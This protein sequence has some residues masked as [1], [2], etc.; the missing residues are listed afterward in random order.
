MPTKATQDIERLREVFKFDPTVQRRIDGDVAAFGKYLERRRD[1]VA[2]SRASA[3]EYDADAVR[4]AD[5]LRTEAHNAAINAAIDLNYLCDLAQM[6]PIAPV[7]E[8]GT[9]FNNKMHR[10]A[11]ARFAADT[12]ELTPGERHACD[13]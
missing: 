10:N 1:H 6:E 9:E 4:G 3:D 2:L 5:N 12:F 8:R 7:A 13:L 11:V